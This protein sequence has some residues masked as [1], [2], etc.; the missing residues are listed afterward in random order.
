[1]PVC[2]DCGGTTIEYDTA[3]GNAFC[4]QCGTVVEEN[5]IVA[6][7]TFGETS[8]GAAMVQGSY[9]GQGQTRARMTGPGGFRGSGESREQTLANARRKIRQAQ[10][11]LNISE[12]TGDQAQRWYTLAVEHRFTK[13]RRSEL[14]VAVCLY[15]ACRMSNTSHML[16]DFSDMLHVNVFVLGMTYLRLVQTLNIKLPLIDPAHY[17][18]RFAAL[19]EFGEE[20]NKVA[21][22]AVRLVQRFNRD[23]MTAGRRPAGICGASL[24]L[25]ARMNNFRR[26]VQEIVQVVKIADVTLKKRLDEFRKTSSGN[27]TV[28]DFR[29][30]WLEEEMDPPAFT[31]GKDKDKKRLK[32]K[33]SKGKQNTK[34]RKKGGESAESSE[35]PSETDEEAIE[36]I[37]R[38]KSPAVNPAIFNQGILAGTQDGSE[39][40]P[41][42]SQ[43]QQS[44][45][46]LFLPDP[47]EDTLHTDKIDIYV[48]DSSIDPRLL[49]IPFSSTLDP[50]GTSE[51]E[52]TVD[53][54]IAGEV[55]EFIENEQG[56]L[57]ANAL[58]VSERR[59]QELSEGVDD[60]LGLDEEELDRLILSEDEVKIKERI[61]VELNKDYL[62]HLATKALREQNGEVSAPKPRKRR[63]T[64]N[65]KPRDASTA[66]GVT[67]AESV[68]NLVTKSKKFSRKINYSAYDSLFGT[69]MGFASQKSDTIDD[70]GLY[71]MTPDQDEKENEE[72]MVV[73]E[74][75]GGGVG[76]GTKRTS[77]KD[78]NRDAPHKEKQ[79]PIVSRTYSDEEPD[80]EEDGEKN[81]DTWGV[82]DYAE[83]FEQEV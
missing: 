78:F 7:V 42:S 70:T 58:K 57:L 66:H 40:E 69:N 31:Q 30:V 6:E 82:D 2:G 33:V 51:F 72:P 62:E 81:D 25:A 37:E 68:R 48:K 61:W 77:R 12:H 5:T 73:V 11:A 29:K 46:P 76:I 38:H 55:S 32:V 14:V 60:L 39:E 80:V 28:S 47:D 17:I 65:N 34:K 27:L 74:E 56:S 45:P 10:A 35:G 44:N 22:D 71:R 63:K 16:I 67:A 36:E 15:V 52:E 19:L 50:K 79:A 26:S 21:T 3:A 1:M 23:W 64:T 41:V 43:N 8:T 75:E 13:G 18:H 83:P 20:T 24:L 9:V 54:F 4:I 49:E 53:S 59:R